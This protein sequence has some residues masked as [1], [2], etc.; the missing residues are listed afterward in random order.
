MRLVR[1]LAAFAFLPL[2]ASCTNDSTDDLILPPPPPEQIITYTNDVKPII[3]NNCLFC[4]T[5]PPQNGAPI[6]LTNY[7]FVKT[8]VQNHGLLDRISRQQGAPGMMPFGGTRLPE[9]AINIVVRWQ[10][11]GLQE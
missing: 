9:S 8:A 4:H 3:D 1:K 6:P 11:Q 10:Q 2:L 7:E 5:N